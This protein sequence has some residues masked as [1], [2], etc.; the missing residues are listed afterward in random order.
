MEPGVFYHQFIE[1]KAFQ[2]C[3]RPSRFL[4]AEPILITV[5]D[6]IDGANGQSLSQLVFAAS[7]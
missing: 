4:K 2:Y 5:E 7:I 3:S 6:A 1:R